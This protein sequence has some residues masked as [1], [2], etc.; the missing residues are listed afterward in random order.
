MKT[1]M[2]IAKDCG[3]SHLSA[4]MKTVVVGEPA[5]V[6][7]DGSV[8]AD[9]AEI[10]GALYRRIEKLESERS[11]AIG[12]LLELGAELPEELEESE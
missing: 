2:E 8:L 4:L 11:K 12:M 5:L 6:D 3:I 10:I 7:P 1:N 9:C